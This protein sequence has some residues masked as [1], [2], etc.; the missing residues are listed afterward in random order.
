MLSRDS[1]FYAKFDSFDGDN[2]YVEELTDTSQ[3]IVKEINGFSDL[4]RLGN[5]NVNHSGTT[6]TIIDEDNYY[7]LDLKDGEKNKISEKYSINREGKI[8]SQNE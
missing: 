8:L 6:M 7:V 5:I 2:L 3:K 4:S 1:L